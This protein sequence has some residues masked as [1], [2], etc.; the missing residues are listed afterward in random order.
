M[1]FLILFLAISLISPVMA[2]QTYKVKRG[3][4]PVI[5]LE[6][7]PENA[8]Y[9]GVIKIKLNDSYTSQM[10]DNPARISADGIVRL[11]I[12][13]ID[14][15][16]AQFGV[17]NFGLPFQQSG[18]FQENSQKGTEHGG[19]ISGINFTLMNRWMLKH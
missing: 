10:D 5:N 18:F 7:V 4:R 16:N 12:F 2:Q 14:Q 17:N 9:K 13:N 15:L 19:S 1:R 11:G 6:S 8:Y 3:E